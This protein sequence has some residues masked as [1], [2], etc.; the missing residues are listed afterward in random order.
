MFRR[1]RHLFDYLFRRSRL[2]DELDEEVRSSF[3]ML[4]DRF[5]ARGMP[6]AAACRAAR[7][8]F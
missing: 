3:E 5:A 8:E 4:A 1:L 2:E 6:L 7:I